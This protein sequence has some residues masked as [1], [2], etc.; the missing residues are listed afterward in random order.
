M[1]KW[2]YE[3]EMKQVIGIL[4]AVRNELGAGWSEEIYHQATVQLLE[5]QHVPFE[6]KPRKSLIHNGVEIHTFEPDLIVWAKII[7]ELKVLRDFKGKEFPKINWAQILQ[8]LKFHKMQLG[9]LVNFA[10]A[11]VG[12]KRIIYQPPAFSI[13][14]DYERMLPHVSKAEKEILRE[15]R[16]HIKGLIQKYGLGYPATVYRKLIAV[17]LAHQDIKCVSDVNIPAMMRDIAVGTQAS[18]FLLVADRFLLQVLTVLDGIPILD[19]LKMQTYLKAL[20]LKVGW[21]LNFGRNTIQIRA[22]SI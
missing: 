7:L 10:H 21:T 15:V 13:E 9:V 20:G 6:S 12:L 14:E 4:Y 5:R 11:K 2:L 22:T 18:Q 1:A 17:E 8:Y 3:D 16:K 19:Y